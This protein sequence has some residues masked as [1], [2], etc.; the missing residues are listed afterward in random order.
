[1]KNIIISLLFTVSLFSST[2]S[3]ERVNEIGNTINTLIFQKDNPNIYCRV[4]TEGQW[5]D[6]QNFLCVLNKNERR[7]FVFN[8]L[9]TNYLADFED[10]VLDNKMSKKQASIETI[11]FTIKNNINIFDPNDFKKFYSLLSFDSQ[12]NVNQLLKDIKENKRYMRKAIR[13][14]LKKLSQEEKTIIGIREE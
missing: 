3:S 13:D 11:L 7:L 8:L 9:F 12:N 1:M 10:L 6:Y 2:L 14:T 4:E 5:K